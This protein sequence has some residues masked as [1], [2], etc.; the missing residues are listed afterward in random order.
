MLKASYKKYILNFK[1]PAGTSRGVYNQKE[2]FFIILEDEYKSNI[3][4]GE[5]GI[6]RGLSHDDIPDYEQKLS[7]ITQNIN[8][9][10]DNFHIELANLPSIRFGIETAFRSLNSNDSFQLFPT[11]FSSGDAGI[12]INSLV[13]MG[14][15]KYMET[16]IKEKLEVGYQCIKMKIGAIDF[17][18][19]LR[20]LR[21]IR[22]KFSKKDLQIRVDANGAF[23]KDNVYK[24]LSALEPLGIHSIEQP[25]MPKQ[26]E[27]MREIINKSPISIALDEELIGVNNIEDKKELVSFLNPHYLVL[28]PSLVGGYIA[29]EEWID[30]TKNN[31]IGYWITSALESNV[32]LNAIAQWTYTLDSDMTQGLGT[33]SL[34][35]NNIESPLSEKNG[36]LY[37]DK[38]RNWNTQA[39]K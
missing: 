24:R 28:K 20:L 16:Q 30:I 23:N 3:G 22:S 11:D 14:D 36:Y 10:I 21:L 5:C 9:Y 12:P 32:G 15:T 29:S 4:I 38:D 39:L 2:T 31:K 7:Y 6:L 8:E 25:I 18:E 37:Y 26:Y 19:E 35:T 34:Y 17:E 27:L 1:V 13:W 33:G